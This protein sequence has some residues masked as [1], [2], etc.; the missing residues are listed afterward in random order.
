LILPLKRLP[1]G[2]HFSGVKSYVGDKNKAMFS[3]TS[4]MRF[5]RF[6]VYSPENQLSTISMRRWLIF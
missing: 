1:Y 3:Y 4:R 2:V 5:L 6:S